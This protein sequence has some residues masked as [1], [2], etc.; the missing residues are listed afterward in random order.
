MLQL[1]EYQ[2]RSLNCLARYL[3]AAVTQGP[4]TPFVLETDRPY[5]PVARLDDLPYVCLRVPTGGGKTLMACH[6]LGIVAREYL[7]AERALCLWLVPSNAILEQTLDALRD[8]SHPYRQ[9]IDMFFAGQVEVMGLGDALYLRRGLLD[10][11]TVIIVSTLAAL[12]VEDTEGRKI[13][14]SSGAL[15]DHFT[16]L[17]PT[18][19]ARLEEASGTGTIAYSLANVL[20]MRRPVVI[21]DEAHNA[22]TP[23]SFETLLRVAPSCVIEFTA[24]PQI[25]HSPERQLFASNILHHVSARELKAAEMLKLPIKLRTRPDWKETIADALQMQRELEAAAAAEQQ[26]TGEYLRPIVLIQAQ[27]QN[28]NRPT[29][30]VEVVR[31]AL[32]ED[33]RIPEAQIAVATGQTREL[34]DVDLKLPTCPIRFIITVQAL[35]E[36]WDCPFAYV[37]CSVAEQHSPRAVEQILGRVLR[38]PQAKRKTRDE[39]NYA[40]AFAASTSFVAT[41]SSLRDALIEN[42][43]QQMEAADLIQGGPAQHQLFVPA[44]LF[45]QAS[46][47]VAQ[48]PRLNE[49]AEDLRQRVY[50]DAATQSL[51]VRGD[52]SPAQAVALRASFS[53]VADRAAVEVL[54]QSLMGRSPSSVTPQPALRALSIP[55]LAVRVHGQLEMFEESFFLDTP[56]NLVV[57]DPYLPDSEFAPQQPAAS[58]G[59]ID[60]AETG[61]LEMREFAQQLH[62]Q[63]SLFGSEPNWTTAALANWLDCH[64]PHPDIPQAQSS[65]FLHNAITRLTDDRGLTVE[66]LARLKYPL[67]KALQRRIDHYRGAQRKIGYQS[68]LF[69]PEPLPVEVDPAVCVTINE[70]NYAPNWYYEGGYRFRNH[71]FHHI[72]ELQPDGDEFDCAAELDRLPSARFWL[73]NL[74]RRSNSFWL[75]TASDRSYPDFIVELLDGRFLVV[76]YKNERDWSNDDSKEKRAVGELWADRSGG[77]CLFIMPKGRDWDAIRAMAGAPDRRR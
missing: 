28:R 7:Q 55:L 41:A 24:T 45:S 75:Q 33:F 65:L 31:Q 14:E 47:S 39:L 53:S 38:M 13:Y 69:G 11:A 58:E 2:E 34:E 42:G 37:L 20:R 56:W 76:E 60:I 70:D 74:P 12:R 15:Q 66:Q 23:L 77:R 62:Q 50:Y 6:A 25:D 19:R 27:P 10:G 29:L 71:L 59:A 35:R 8:R 40:Y 1:R 32:V 18:L 57:C 16:N 63:L 3:N 36:G 4:K 67:L 5:R 46:V 22:R 17:P 64:I 49:L 54:E 44:D 73:R 26:T 51:T 30:T 43:F 21:M 68:V 52:L 9:A 72:G 61:K 48:A